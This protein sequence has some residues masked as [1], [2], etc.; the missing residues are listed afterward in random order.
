MKKQ[1]YH[2]YNLPIGDIKLKF[3]SKNKLS[4]DNKSITAKCLGCDKIKQYAINEPIECCKN[5]SIVLLQVAGFYN[6]TKI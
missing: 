3:K 6:Q 1:K 4:F 2:K 5:K